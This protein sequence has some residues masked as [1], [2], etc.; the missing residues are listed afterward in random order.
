MTANS[1]TSELSQALAKVSPYATQAKAYLVPV[2]QEAGKRALEAKERLTP[3]INEAVAKAGPALVRGVDRAQVLLDT[4]VRPRLVEFVE[5]TQADPRVEEAALRG[6]SAVAALRGELV[7]V[8][9]Q[10]AKKQKKAKKGHPVLK[11]IGLSVL[12]AGAGL[13]AVAVIRTILGEKDDLWEQP[14]P[15]AQP[16]ATPN[17]PKHSADT[18]EAQPT[19][20]I[21]GVEEKMEYYT[22]ETPE[23]DQVVPSVWFESEEAAQAA[24]FSPAQ[25]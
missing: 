8:E 16:E 11:G 3:L 25:Q 13:V 9:P 18:P 24:G 14:E 19:G 4:E 23:Y 10:P 22:P 12:A 6:R 5:K 1:P 17:E 15:P 7:L 21:K 2:A 20:T